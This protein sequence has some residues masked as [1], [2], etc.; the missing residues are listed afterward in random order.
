MTWTTVPFILTFLL[1]VAGLYAI[2]AK[3]NQIGRAH[4]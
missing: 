2:V 3:R 4:V 1:L